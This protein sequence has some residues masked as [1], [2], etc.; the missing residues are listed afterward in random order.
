MY[1]ITNYITDI[2]SHIYQDKLMKYHLVFKKNEQYRK[3]YKTN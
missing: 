2:S 1:I 3:K